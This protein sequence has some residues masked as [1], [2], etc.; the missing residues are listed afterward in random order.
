MKEIPITFD[1]KGKRYSGHFSLVSGAGSDRTWH[2]FIALHYY[3]RLRFTD[4]WIFD[5]ELM[6]EM[7]GEFGEYVERWGPVQ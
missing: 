2:L 3:G 6:P 7:A 4:R 5:S 1:H